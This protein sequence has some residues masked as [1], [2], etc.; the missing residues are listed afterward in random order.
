MDPARLRL[1]RELGDRGSVAAVAAAMHVNEWD[2]S[3]Q[4][5]ALVGREL[6]AG[7]LRDETVSL[8]DL[9]TGS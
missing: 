2:A 8:E 4:V 6:A 7:R 9:G 1:L 5:R 3:D